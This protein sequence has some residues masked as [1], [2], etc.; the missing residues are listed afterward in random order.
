MPPTPQVTFYKTGLKIG[1]AFYPCLPNS[2]EL[3]CPRNFAIPPIIGNFWQLNYADGLRQ[4]VVNTQ[5]VIRSNTAEVLSTTFLDYF[6]LR[7]NDLKHD[8]PNINSGGNG[9]TFFDGA[10]AFNMGGGAGG[11]VKA[12]AFTLMSSKGE[13]LI[14][15]AQ[16]LGNN[17]VPIVGGS[18]AALS[19]PSWSKDPPLRFQNVNFDGT[20]A[21]EVWRFSLA[22]SN[23]CNPNLAM[24]QTVFPADINGGLQTCGLSLTMQALSTPPADESELHL[25]IYPAQQNAAAAHGN[26]GGGG[27]AFRNFKMAAPINNTRDDRRLTAPRIMRNYDYIVLGGDSQAIPPL[28][29]V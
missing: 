7:S 9:I 22:Y 6:M 24:D 14:F 4:P 13:D 11:I 29:Y 23:N 20:A 5:I 21:N 1:N 27:S 10:S 28:S 26:D 19:A 16:F 18:L 12:N 17:I 15:N 25:F 8:M 3:I 2:T